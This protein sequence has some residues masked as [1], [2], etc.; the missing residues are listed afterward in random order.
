MSDEQLNPMQS[1]ALLVGR[2]AI[3]IIFVISFTIKVLGP[4][5]TIE[6]IDGVLPVPMF[7]YLGSL[8]LLG[9]GAVS[10]LFG[11]YGRFGA[12]CLALFV[13]TAAIF[14]HQFWTKEGDAALSDTAHF[15]KNMAIM[16]GLLSIAVFGTGPYSV[17]RLWAKKADA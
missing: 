13:F 6:Q 4:S 7:W 2:I 8:F 10:V 15:L 11:V 14:F 5:D 12:S 9:V 17:D 3:A 1:S 16:G